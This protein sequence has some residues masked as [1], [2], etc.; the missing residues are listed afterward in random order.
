MPDEGEIT[1]SSAWKAG[2]NFEIDL[3]FQ[4]VQNSGLLFYV[5]SQSSNIDDHVELEI[6]EGK[7]SYYWFVF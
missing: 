6:V 1:P 5:Q 7:V 2:V 4:T 3:E